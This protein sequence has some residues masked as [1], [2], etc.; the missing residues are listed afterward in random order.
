MNGRVKT[1][2]TV[3]FF[4]R[5]LR[6][7]FAT[8]FCCLFVLPTELVFETRECLIYSQ[9]KRTVDFNAQ[10]GLIFRRLT[11]NTGD[12]LGLCVPCPCL[13]ENRRN[14]YCRVVLNSKHL[15]HEEVIEMKKLLKG[16]GTVA[17]ALALAL[18]WAWTGW[19]KDAGYI[20]DKGRLQI[21]IVLTILLALQQI[22]LAI[23]SPEKRAVVE[24]RR[25]I[26][27]NYLSQFRAKYE[28]LIKKTNGGTTVPPVRVNIMLPVKRARGLL[29]S[30]LQVYFCSFPSGHAYTDDE[31]A[32][33][34]ASEE[35]TCGWAWKYGIRSIY[36]SVRT[37]YKLSND[38]LKKDKPAVVGDINSAAS[39]P[40]WY[41]G[42]VVAVFSLDSQC[43]VTETHFDDP[44]IYVWAAGFADT[45][46]V[47]CYPH[48]IEA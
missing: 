5:L 34:W 9:A 29:G 32:L 26:N 37:D 39:F 43:N 28:S 17:L 40:I 20:D 11:G 23:P 46:G 45:L 7:F 41:N 35:G 2:L 25:A 8:N 31:L 10:E 16:T 4:Q 13:Y 12:P 3:Q 24:K 33:K 38:R 47:Q 15:L 44:E 36:D 21:L 30:Y 22:Y 42:N 19:L 27:E 14:L 48:G 18:G 1:H 6:K